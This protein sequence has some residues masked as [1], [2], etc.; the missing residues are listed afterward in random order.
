MEF[1][2]EFLKYAPCHEE[3]RCRP[4]TI[5]EVPSPNCVECEKCLQSFKAGVTMQW[6]RSKEKS[7]S[8]KHVSAHPF[9]AKSSPV[10]QDD[11]GQGC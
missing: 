2:K 6:N 7:K 8:T 9:S 4:S 11:G 1:P 10:V 5:A 3:P